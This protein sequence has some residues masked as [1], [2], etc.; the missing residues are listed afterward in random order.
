[1][2]YST[3]NIDVLS[4]HTGHINRF[5]EMALCYLFE[6][7]L[8]TPPHGRHLLSPCCPLKTPSAFP[9]Q[10]ICTWYSLVGRLF[11]C[12]FNGWT[13]TSHCLGLCSNAVSSKKT[14]LATLVT[15][16]PLSHHL[17]IFSWRLSCSNTIF[18]I[19]WN[20]CLNR[21]FLF[22]C[23]LFPLRYKFHY[24]GDFV[25]CIYSCIPRVWN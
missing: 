13:V 21:E 8:S 9:L 4:V 19:C 14:F 6:F 11:L 16:H 22:C 1:M 12:S 17:I 18:T 3:K 10:S 24:D 23:C 7:T 15:S 5:K 2:T 20:L 25:S